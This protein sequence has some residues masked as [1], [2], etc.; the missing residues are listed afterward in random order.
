VAV[1]VRTPASYADLAALPDHLIGEIINGE[2][3]TSP[4][5][6]PLHAAAASALG[7][8]LFAPFGRGRGGPGGW[9]IL[10][11]PELHLSPGAAIVVPDLA[12]WRTERMPSLPETAW[13]ELA[14]DWVGEVASPATAALDR[15]DKMPIYARAG[16]SHL[17]L[18]DPKLQLLETYELEGERWL[19]LETFRGEAKVRAV[20]FDAIELELGALWAS[21][22]KGA[23]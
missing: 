2:L 19:L 15:A 8:E 23:E 5:P 16:V 13:F 18:I 20:P 7:G 9:W 11:E 22:S 3:V 21:G 12:G 10:D 6:G 14:P 1:P 17:W 4:R